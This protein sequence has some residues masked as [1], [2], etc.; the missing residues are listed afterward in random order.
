M[1]EEYVDNVNRQLMS[2]Q[3]DDETRAE[4]S[5]AFATF[6]KN[7]NGFI[8]GNE[9]KDALNSSYKFN[10]VA[11]SMADIYKK[12]DLNQDSRIS[13]PDFAKIVEKEKQ[14]KLQFIKSD[15]T[16]EV[17]EEVHV[18]TGKGGHGYKQVGR[19]EVRAFSAYLN[20]V[21]ADDEDCK[22]LGL[23]PIGLPTESYEQYDLYDKVQDGVLFCK[24]V[25]LV[26]P[27]TIPEKSIST[28]RLDQVFVR[29][30]NITLAVNS[31]IAIGCQC[32]GTTHITIRDKHD[33][34]ILGLLWQLIRKNSFKAINLREN[35]NLATLLLPGETLD[36]LMNLSPEELLLRWVNYHLDKD[37]NYKGKKINNFSK[38]IK[39]GNAY[40]SL[41][42]QIQPKEDFP[43]FGYDSL[44][45][46]DRDRA[47]AV[48]D[49]AGRLGCG[50]YITADDILE[51]QERVNTLFVSHLFNTHPALEPYE[52]EE[53]IEI[54]DE[55]REEK[56]FKNWINSLGLNGVPQLQFLYPPL[57]GG[58]VILKIEDAIEIGCV[59]WKRVNKTDTY[60]RI[61][62]LQRK[63]ENC[64]Y[65]IEVARVLG[66]KIIGI[67]GANIS[68]GHQMFILAIV[69]QLMR[70]YTLNIIRGTIGN[71][72]EKEADK[73]IV[74]WANQKLADTG[75]SSSFTSFNDKS[76]A[77]SRVILDLVDAIKPG[78]VDLDNLTDDDLE[79]AR[80]A[81]TCCRKIGAVVYALPEDIVEVNKKM[82]MTIFAVLMGCGLTGGVADDGDHEI[83]TFKQN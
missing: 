45:G 77:D 61:G 75:K 5:E 32:I 60:K 2:L 68:D 55:T 27:G 78:S 64:N 18:V 71:A 1:A 76:L 54:A 63:L 25:N 79:N 70:K 80:Y 17:T 16:T 28:A 4:I 33:N 49:Y 36:D 73:L 13:L 74:N 14:I 12:Y 22:R 19:G 31:A 20:S 37:D 82:I 7:Q 30:E 59:D 44:G 50:D 9:L 8:D 11:Y 66:C 34:I 69:W 38:D 67:D 52:A 57:S 58:V 21:L 42:N 56:T 15:K 47:N 62:G 41:L 83:Q 3:I 26:E 6:D 53:E 23:V 72:N 51:G 43:K 24:L 10:F 40:V 48:N 65:A 39:N 81:I 46:S 29:M 35:H